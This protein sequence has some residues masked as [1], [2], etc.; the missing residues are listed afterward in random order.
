MTKNRALRAPTLLWVSALLA[1]AGCSATPPP[2]GQG[3]D[4]AI[5]ANIKAQLIASPDLSSYPIDVAT[6]QGVVQLS[7]RVDRSE[8][9]K[10]VERLA[11]GTS[12]VR[13]V[14]DDIVIKPAQSAHATKAPSDAEIIARVKT[15]L[16]ADPS[17]NPLAIEVSVHGGVV[18]LKGRVQTSAQSERAEQIVRQIEGVQGVDNQLQVSRGN[19]E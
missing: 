1:L 18:T 3:D 14:R 17:I 2:S 16:S 5:T 10:E 12:G 15:R 11:R 7:G 9:R 13:A 6:S 19:S 8:Q 4:A